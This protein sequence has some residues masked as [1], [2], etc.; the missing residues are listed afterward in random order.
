[1]LSWLPGIAPG[2][3]PGGHPSLAV[4]AGLSPCPIP[5]SDKVGQALA[6][7]SGS[8]S[9]WK[10]ALEGSGQEA[11]GLPGGH[12]WRWGWRGSAFFGV[13]RI[14]FVPGVLGTLPPC[15]GLAAGR[16]RSG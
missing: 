1:M 11:G 9:R 12:S 2:H 7:G 14:P 13:C 5:R 4:A 3:I 15:P 16:S 10:D 8:G 6:P